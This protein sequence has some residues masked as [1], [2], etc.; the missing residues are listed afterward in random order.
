M[1]NAQILKIEHFPYEEF[2]QDGLLIYAER[3]DGFWF[4]YEHDNN[5]NRNYYEDSKGHW[6]RRVYDDAGVCIYYEDEKVKL[7][8]LLVH[9][10]APHP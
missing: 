6:W 5:G 1:T 3:S 2:D 9:W 10:R 8:P 7:G 4:R